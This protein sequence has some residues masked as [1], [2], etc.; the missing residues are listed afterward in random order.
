MGTDGKNG[1]SCS[2][3]SRP[4]EGSESEQL[5]F[6]SLDVEGVKTQ[7]REHAPVV[8]IID[9]EWCGDCR[10]QMRNLPPFE[11]RLKEAGIS[12]YIFTVEGPQYDVFISP[13]HK[14]L[15]MKFY[16]TPVGGRIFEQTAAT[17]TDTSSVM[18]KRGREGYPA[19]FFVHNGIVKLWSIEDVSPK[20]L[21]AIGSAILDSL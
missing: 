21:E 2:I 19:I 8:F 18:A 17:G 3:H 4:I 10:N 6:A 11:A 16:S 15:A 14:E 5:A 12:T 9:A 1:P 20:Q 13:A 7:L